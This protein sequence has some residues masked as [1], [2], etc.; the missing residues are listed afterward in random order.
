MAGIG[1][2]KTKKDGIRSIEN[3]EDF[4]RPRGVGK[5]LRIDFQLRDMSMK[6]VVFFL[7]WSANATH[8]ACDQYGYPDGDKNRREVVAQVR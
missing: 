1:V 7:A 3:D 4:I 8:R 2:G 6:E 5:P